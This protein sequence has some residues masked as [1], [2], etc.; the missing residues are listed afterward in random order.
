[1]L[2]VLPREEVFVH[3]NAHQLRDDQCG[4]RVIEMD[5]NLVRQVGKRAVDRHVVADDARQEAE[6][7]KYCCVRR[8]S[9]PSAWLSEGYSTLVIASALVFSSIACAYC[10][11]VNRPMLKSW[12]SCARHS[13]RRL[14]AS[15]SAPEIIMS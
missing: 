7:R 9:L 1:M 11:C 2:G 12:I 5:G 6:Q 8:S 10:P 14:T 15:E 13:R 4:M 3:Q